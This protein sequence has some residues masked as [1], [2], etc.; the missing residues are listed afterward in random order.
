M[1]I[2]TNDEV[3]IIA[4]K[5]RGKRGRVIRVMKTKRKVVV[6]GIN[7][8]TRHLKRNPQNPESGGRVKRP[9]PID[10]SNVMVWSAADDKAVRIRVE[11]DGRNKRRVSA[12]TGKVVSASGGR[13]VRKADK[14]QKEKPSSSEE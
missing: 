5:D 8:V 3:L 14:A 6:D 11:G 7:V 12:K 1:K 4:G 13:K 2:H 9:A 10:I